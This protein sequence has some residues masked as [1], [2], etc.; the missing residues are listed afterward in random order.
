MC[1][2]GACKAIKSSTGIII[3]FPFSQVPTLAALYL[4]VMHKL[5]YTRITKIDY[6]GKSAIKN[7]LATEIP[8]EL[9]QFGIFSHMLIVT[10]INAAGQVSQFFVPV[11][12]NQDD[13]N[14]KNKISESTFDELPATDF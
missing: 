14:K 9:T 8:G 13:D 1:I 6:M 5:G 11:V 10:A 3:P 7:L 2:G 12:Q 4:T